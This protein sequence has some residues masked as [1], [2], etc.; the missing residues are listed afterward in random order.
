VEKLKGDVGV[1]THFLRWVIVTD[2]GMDV[3]VW[4]DRLL[5]VHGRA[6]RTG[7]PAVY[8]AEGFLMPTARMN[9]YLWE[10]LETTSEEEFTGVSHVRPPLRNAT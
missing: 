7:G 2:S 10:A 8:D 9:D 5:A 3:Q 4:R 6:G 1:N